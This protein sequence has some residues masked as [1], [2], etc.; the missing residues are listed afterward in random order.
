MSFL[1]NG[2]FWIMLAVIG[3]LVDPRYHSIDMLP[4][5]A[6]Y[7]LMILGLRL[8]R[9]EDRGFGRLVP[10]AIVLAVLALF[11]LRTDSLF[12]ARYGDV[13]YYYNPLIYIEWLR[14]AGEVAFIWI[15]C[16]TVARIARRRHLTRIAETAM[17]RANLFAA[18]IP[19]SI[20][21]QGVYLLLPQTTFIFEPVS[22]F[23]EVLA[24]LLLV[25]LMWN[26]QG[27]LRPQA[28]EPKSAQA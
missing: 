26:L 14:M 16:R 13:T 3:L 22:I 6:A 9:H 25:D 15:F 28:A 21:A 18:A 17:E 11:D 2:Y 20:A 10:F 12:L 23:I 4:D 27:Q 8:L 19:I 1:R 24:W 7:L 5:T